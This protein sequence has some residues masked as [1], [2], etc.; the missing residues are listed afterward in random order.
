MTNPLDN[1]DAVQTGILMA[2]YGVELIRNERA[3]IATHLLQRIAEHQA[4]A[5]T[6]A[7]DETRHAAL[8]YAA[9]YD[10]VARY[11]LARNG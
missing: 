3:A 9:V 11:V 6:T 7:D 1:Q 8:M 5:A 2:L 10:E 4:I